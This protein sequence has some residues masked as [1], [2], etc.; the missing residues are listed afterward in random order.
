MDVSHFVNDVM[1]F[2]KPN[3]SIHHVTTMLMFQKRRLSNW[4]NTYIPFTYFLNHHVQ[5]F[6]QLFRFC[7]TLLPNT[8]PYNVDVSFLKCTGG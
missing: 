2:L 5:V 3:I 4:N 8:D 1:L 6:R 7:H